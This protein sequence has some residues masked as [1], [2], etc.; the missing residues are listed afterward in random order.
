MTD[1]TYNPE[2]PPASVASGADLPPA[3]HVRG[4]DPLRGHADVGPTEGFETT[5]L[6]DGLKADAAELPAN[7]YG[8]TADRILTPE[9]AERFTNARVHAGAVRE[10]VIEELAKGRTED[11]VRSDIEKDLGV[12]EENRAKQ[13]A[14]EAADEARFA[15]QSRRVERL[16][17]ASII[18]PH[19]IAQA[20][21][22]ADRR[23]IVG[24]AVA[25]A[26]ELIDA[27]AIPD[28]A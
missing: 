12:F 8:E 9:V 18:L 16:T 23:Q 15:A 6:E 24:N 14:Q 7:V 4:V 2:N 5:T 3:D 20:D 22:K 1:Q 28:E 13:A 10:A 19:L 21:S 11:E 25:F 17:T 26:D 27:V